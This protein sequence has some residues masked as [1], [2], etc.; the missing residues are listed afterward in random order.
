[1]T[2]RVKWVASLA[3]VAVFALL[4]FYLRGADLRSEDRLL[5]QCSLNALTG[6]HCPGCGNTRAASAILHGDIAGAVEQNILFVIAIPFLGL[7]ALR[8]W[9][10]WVYPGMWKP[11]P[12]RWRW[13][14]S[15][16]IISVVVAFGI[17]RNVPSQPYSW[18][19]PVPLAR[20]A[21]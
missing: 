6:L 16:A 14:Y 10:D 1:M 20:A 19:A 13:S 11:L 9:T 21:E 12:F 4:A 15:L 17:L 2:L 5:P 3:S 7:G 8:L 18:L